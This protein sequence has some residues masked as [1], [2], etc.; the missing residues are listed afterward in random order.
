MFIGID[1]LFKIYEIRCWFV[2]VILTQ[3]L[4]QYQGLYTQHIS[5]QRATSGTLPGVINQ[6]IRCGYWKYAI[7]RIIHFS[8]YEL[9]FEAYILFMLNVY[10]CVS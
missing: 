3:A 1:S 4:Q 10:V 5:F 8:F 6:H 9:V 2:E 7:P